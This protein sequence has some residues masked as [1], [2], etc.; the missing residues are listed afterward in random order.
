[1]KIAKKRQFTLEPKAWKILR[2]EVLKDSAV[3]GY[4]GTTTIDKAYIY[5]PY[6]PLQII[7]GE[8]LPEGH[9]EIKFRTRYDT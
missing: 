1:M 8:F 5:C 7:S 9:P 6:I 3:V 4:K 2:G